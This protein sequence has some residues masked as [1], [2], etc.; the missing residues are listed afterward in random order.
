MA[1]CSAARRV[2]WKGVSKVDQWVALTVAW[3]AERCVA[4]RADQWAAMMA[5]RALLRVA[6]WAASK[7]ALKVGQ[8]AGKTAVHK[9]VRM[10]ACYA[11][12]KSEPKVS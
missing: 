7:A 9:V 11:A 1:V 8:M 10:A 12:L 6:S 2:V 5:R 3:M 4:L